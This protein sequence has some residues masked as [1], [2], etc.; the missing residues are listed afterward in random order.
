MTGKA[1]LYFGALTLRRK[2]AF[3][4]PRRCRNLTVS[5][6]FTMMRQRY[7]TKLSLTTYLYEC[8]LRTSVYGYDQHK[9]FLEASH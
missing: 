7:N 3:K 5:D 4:L 6:E 9:I 1:P 8:H 2:G